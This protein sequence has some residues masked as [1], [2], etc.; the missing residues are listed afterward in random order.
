MKKQQIWRKMLKSL[1]IPND[2][3]IKNK[4]IH[5]MKHNGV[6]QARLIACGYS[7]AP[8]VDFSKIIC[9]L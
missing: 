6:Y 1:M 9:L 4:R 8:G 5:K 3:C 2:R 7:Q